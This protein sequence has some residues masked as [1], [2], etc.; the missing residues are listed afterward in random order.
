MY[1]VANTWNRIHFRTWNQVSTFNLKTVI[2]LFILITYFINSIRTHDMP[3]HTQ[4]LESTNS[5]SLSTLAL[6]IDAYCV[7]SS[8]L[9]QFHGLPSIFVTMVRRVVRLGINL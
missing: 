1:A 4:F 8:V 6:T 7:V 2:F 3:S 9:L 5:T